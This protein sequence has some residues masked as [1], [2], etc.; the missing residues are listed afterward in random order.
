MKQR[1]GSV[2]KLRTSDPLSSLRYSARSKCRSAKVGSVDAGANTSSLVHVIEYGLGLDWQIVSEAI[3]FIDRR[4]LSNGPPSGTICKVF[5]ICHKRR[6]PKTHLL[7]L[8]LFPL[9][10]GHRTRTRRTAQDTQIA[11]LLL[12][13]DDSQFDRVKIVRRCHLRAD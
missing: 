8:R 9:R 13:K 4:S 1:N 11:H 10:C 3:E 6:L 5:I 2:R 7:I 12:S